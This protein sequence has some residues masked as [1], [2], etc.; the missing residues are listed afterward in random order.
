MPIDTSIYGNLLAAPK[1]AMEWQNAYAAQDD[2]RQTRQLNALQLQDTMAK[3]QDADVARGEDRALRNRL[4][5]G[6][7]ISTPEGQKELYQI[8]PKAAPG[9][10][11]NQVE[12]DEKRT[13]IRKGNEETIDKRLGFYRGY[14]DQLGGKQQAAQWLRAQY[15]DPVVG[16]LVS[17]LGAFDEVIGRIPDE[18]VDPNGFAQWRMQSKDGMKATIEHFSPKPVQITAGGRVLTVDHN[19]NSPT[20]NQELKSYSAANP[21]QDLVIDGQDGKPMPN[22]PVIDAKSQIGR[23]SAN[24]V[25]VKVDAK[26]GEG[27]AKEVGPMIAGSASGAE[28]ALNQMQTARQIIGAI[29]SGNVIAGPG[30]SWRLGAK[31]FAQTL[32]LSGKDDAE[33]IANTRTVIQG[34][35]QQIVNARKQLAGQGQVSD[36]EQRL[37]ERAT[38]GSI[39]ELTAPEIKQLAVVNQRLSKQVIQ[40]HNAKLDKLKAD[41]ATSGLATFFEAIP[42]DD[43]PVTPKPTGKPGAAPN[44]I[45]FGDLK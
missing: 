30:A 44:V 28:G 29:D 31:Q 5:G 20:F 41:P 16:P 1:S 10:L 26:L 18:R 40:R 13:Q 25:N 35:A 21:Y 22:R 7:D 12:L 11:K 8:A 3:L 42:V 43:D 33:A 32:G 27:L 24:N 4:A 14:A 37:L 9:M 39:D 6:L 17:K 15:D 23:A 2:A 38:S 34:M 45:N 36:S 19:P